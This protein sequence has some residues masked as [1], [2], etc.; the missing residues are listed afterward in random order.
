MKANLQGVERPQSVAGLPA[1]AASS[2][3]GASAASRRQAFPPSLIGGERVAAGQ[4][5]QTKGRC[6]GSL[7]ERLVMTATGETKLTLRRHGLNGDAAFVD[8]LNFTVG[9]ES[10]DWSTSSVEMSE[11]RIIA[12]A[13]FTLAGIFGFGVTKKLPNGRNF[14]N[15]SYSL[16]D[17]WGFVAIGGQRNTVMVSISGTGLAAARDGWESRLHAWLETKAKR[18]KLTRVDVAHDCYRGQY[19]VDQARDDYRAGGAGTEGRMPVC[20]ERGDWYRP[21]GSGRTF[22]IG[23]R[24]NGKYARVYEKGKQ[25]G[26]AKSPWV[27]LEVEFKAVD[28][29]LPFDILLR[30]GEYLAG[31]YPMFEWINARAERIA[32]VKKALAAGYERAVTYARRQVGGA[33]A[34]I[35]EMEGGVQQAFDVLR[36]DVGKIPAWVKKAAPSL[37]DSAVPVHEYRRPPLP[38]GLVVERWVAQW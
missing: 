25:L 2:D 13:S 14:Y 26:D 29:L 3:E 4:E 27:R 31:A 8:W 32:T 10:F 9:D 28:R 34:F 17:E 33:L 12:D 38:E 1:F 19:T 35:A 36:R 23:K 11:D 7:V 5:G 37:E 21:N 30:P 18:A 16:G 22:Y 6:S 15:S 20:E 24:T